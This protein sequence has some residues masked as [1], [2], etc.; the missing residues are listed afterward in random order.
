MKFYPFDK[1]RSKGGAI[2]LIASLRNLACGHK[3]FWLGTTQS[4]RNRL[5]RAPPLL[6]H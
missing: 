1:D 3:P 5:G 2:P 6:I 4:H